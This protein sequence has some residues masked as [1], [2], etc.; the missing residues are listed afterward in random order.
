MYLDQT[1]PRRSG[2]ISAYQPAVELRNPGDGVV[3]FWT[4]P[5]VGV[6]APAHP[7]TFVVPAQALSTHA[8]AIDGL[9]YNANLGI[10]VTASPQ[11]T[12]VWGTNPAFVAQNMCATL[13]APESL[14]LWKEYLPTISYETVCG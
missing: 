2:A 6:P 4:V 3:R 13:K 12:R 11:G 14:A 7:S 8:G 10:I 9:A 1:H 5:D